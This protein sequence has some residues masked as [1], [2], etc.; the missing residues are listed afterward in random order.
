[1]AKVSQIDR[2]IAELQARKAAVAE[3]AQ[4]EMLGLEN[5]IGALRAQQR[6]PAKPRAVAKAPEAQ[7]A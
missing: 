5:A 2:A 6:K 7:S 4:A 3:K 1:V